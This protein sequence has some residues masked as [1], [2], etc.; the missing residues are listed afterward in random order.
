MSSTPLDSAL[1]EQI[2]QEVIRRLLQ[3]GVGVGDAVVSTPPATELE[4]DDRLVTLATLQ[5]RL[6]GVGKLVV[7]RRA[8]VTPA[9]IDELNDRGIKLMRK[10]I[11]TG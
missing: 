2:V 3:R 10:E 11:G 1:F 8:V 9:V 6:D 7:A 4:L 5:N